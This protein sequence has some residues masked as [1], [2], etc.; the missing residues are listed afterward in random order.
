[1]EPGQWK[2]DYGDAQIVPIVQPSPEHR[3]QEIWAGCWR[4][5]R[6]PRS[7]RTVQ[8]RGIRVSWLEKE[9]I[10]NSSPSTKSESSI[11]TGVMAP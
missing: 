3:D 6:E 9:G 7:G 1:M 2:R 4:D 5:F 11:A 10:P 8:R